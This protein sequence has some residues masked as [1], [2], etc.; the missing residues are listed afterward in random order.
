MRAEPSSEAE[1]VTVLGRGDEVADLGEEVK[2]VGDFWWRHVRAGD[3]EGWV[4]DSYALPGG[5]YDAF[6]EADELGKAGKADAMVTAAWEGGEKI[7]I[8]GRRDASN[9]VS[10]DGKKVVL[11]GAWS[12]DGDMDWGW[13]YP[14]GGRVYSPFPVL[15]FVSGKGLVDYFRSYDDIE[16]EWSPD[17]RYYVYTARPVAEYVSGAALWYFD[18]ETGER[19]SVGATKI[20]HPSGGGVEYE[21]TDGYLIWTGVE[22][23]EEPGPPLLEKDSTTPALAACELATGRKMKLLEADLDTLGGEEECETGCFGIRYYPVKMV[24]ADPCPC[25]PAVEKSDLYIKYHDK[26]GYAANREH[27]LE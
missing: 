25:P 27:F 26:Y 23:V 14:W 19:V 17:S 10:P 3:N 15:F 18:S 8:W 20:L 2:E 21:L 11:I 12:T 13:G 22:A 16:G 4:N 5:F 9:R 7:G 24:T 6:R 1:V